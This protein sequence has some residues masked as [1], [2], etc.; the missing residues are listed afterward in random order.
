MCHSLS[1]DSWI[2][3]SWGCA[4]YRCQWHRG[5]AR[6]FVDLGHISV[7]KKYILGKK[8][9]LFFDRYVS[10][11]NQKTRRAPMVNGRN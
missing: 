4:R 11:I 3:S 9:I 5:P 8:Y 1:A 7:E 2:M 6:F 10:Q